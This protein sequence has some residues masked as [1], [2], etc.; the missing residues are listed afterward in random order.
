[1]KRIMIAVDF[2]AQTQ[3]IL[4]QGYELAGKLGAE[5]LLLHVEE[6]EAS[7]VH[8]NVIGPYGGMTGFGVDM[9][10]ATEIVDDQVERDEAIMET[11]KKQGEAQ[12]LTVSTEVFIGNEVAG[13]IR[14][15]EQHKPD[16][17]IMG[18]HHKG[19]FS[20]LLGENPELALVKKAPC[21]LFFIP[22]E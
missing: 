10:T 11:L 22:E 21:A 6:P 20:R 17:L 1:M 7:V 9:P 3:R 16:L 8:S 14:E 18:L 12:G 5:V 13:I 15:C 4:K 19:F 2:S